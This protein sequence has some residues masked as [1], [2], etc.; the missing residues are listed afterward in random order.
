[1]DV[2]D[3]EARQRQSEA[4]RHVHGA[5]VDH[6][7]GAAPVHVLV[8]PLGLGAEA[9][10]GPAGHR[11][12]LH[13]LQGRLLAVD[14]LEVP[15]EA[16]L[17]QALAD[18]LGERT[19]LRVPD[20]GGADAGGIEVTGRS[21]RAVEARAGLVGVFDQVEL[22]GVAVDGVDD[23]VEVFQGEAVTVLAGIH[24]VDR[25]HLDLGMQRDQAL[26]Q[27]LHLGPAHV[28]SGGLQL[29]VDVGDAHLVG[30]HQGQVPHAAAGQGFGAPAPHPSHPE[31]DHA[32]GLQ[33]FQGT[34]PDQELQAMKNRM[35]HGWAQC[36]N[37]RSRQPWKISAPGS[38]DA[39]RGPGR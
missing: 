11:G 37:P 19:D 14:H 13:R 28:P 27:F 17:A 26:A 7:L 12:V 2:L 5:A 23:V 10:V 20:A 15:V 21:H 29:A 4:R 34:G 32:R 36:I 8:L 25:L 3:H 6:E 33:K 35:R 1:M 9:L 31:H 18:D 16:P 24:P 38:E 30:I 22:V 39:P